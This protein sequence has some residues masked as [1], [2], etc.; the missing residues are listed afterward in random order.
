MQV[1]AEK[2]YL[3]NTLLFTHTEKKIAMLKRGLTTK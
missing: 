1:A 2:K 3:E